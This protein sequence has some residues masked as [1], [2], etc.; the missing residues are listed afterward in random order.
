MISARAEAKR[1]FSG[2]KPILDKV[3]KA[4]DKREV[5]DILKMYDD[6]ISELEDPDA[7]KRSVHEYK[8]AYDRWLESAGFDTPETRNRE[9]IELL[10]ELNSLK[11]QIKKRLES[12]EKNERVRVEKEIAGLL[13]GFPEIAS[14][15]AQNLQET[16]MGRVV[17]LVDGYK[18]ILKSIT[19]SNQDKEPDPEK[20]EPVESQNKTGEG[21]QDSHE[22]PTQENPTHEQPRKTEER[23]TEYREGL[24]LVELDREALEKLFKE[25]ETI[26]KSLRE[27]LSGEENV[28]LSSFR[29]ALKKTLFNYC[30]NVLKMDKKEISAMHSAINELVDTVVED[31]GSILD[32]SL[33]LEAKKQTGFFKRKLAGI[34]GRAKLSW[35]V[36]ILT[37]LG[38][39]LL[40]RFFLPIGNRWA[41][42]GITGL[43][44]GMT[45]TVGQYASNLFSRWRRKRKGEVQSD[46]EEIQQKEQKMIDDKKKKLL[47]SEDFSLLNSDRLANIVAT[48]TYAETS[49]GVVD[50]DEKLDFSKMEQDESGKYSESEESKRGR[51]ELR[52]S[53]KSIYKNIETHVNHDPEY[54]DLVPR[55]KKLEIKRLFS[56]VVREQMNQEQ[57]M[58]IMRN[59]GK[60]N[61]E[62]AQSLAKFQ[63][64]VTGRKLA[65]NLDYEA[66]VNDMA[67]HSIVAGLVSGAT[68]IAM[69]AGGDYARAGL[70]ALGGATMGAMMFDVKKDKIFEE[71]VKSLD[72]IVSSSEGKIKDIIRS[73]D[74][75]A[76]DVHQ[77]LEQNIAYVRTVLSLKRDKDTPLIDDPALRTRAEGMIHQFNMIKARHGVSDIA[78]H[79]ERGEVYNI[80]NENRFY[81]VLGK[82]ER[83]LA[84][85]R[86]EMIAGVAEKVE[87]AEKRSKWKKK[88][89]MIVGGIAGGVLGYF[90]EDISGKVGGKIRDWL[91]LEQ[92][93]SQQ[94]APNQEPELEN[95]KN[96]PIE[97][98]GGSGG[99]SDSSPDSSRDSGEQFQESPESRQSESA[100]GDSS[101]TTGSSLPEVP[102]PESDLDFPEDAKLFEGSIDSKN[103]SIWKATK[104][105][106]LSHSEEF[107][108]DPKKH[109]D[110]KAWAERSTANAI[111]ELNELE[112]GNIKD[113]V[114]K[115]DRVYIGKGPDGKYHLSVED[116]PDD[117]FE[118]GHLS[119]SNV[120][121]IV[122]DE[123]VA[124]GVEVDNTGRSSLAGDQYVEYTK[125]GE[126]YRVYDWNRDGN[127]NVI[128]PDGT[129]VEMTPE[130]L[131]TYLRAEGIYESEITEA[132]DVEHGLENEVPDSVAQDIELAKETGSVAEETQGRLYDEEVK[133][134]KY[135]Q[136]SEF[137]DTVQG[138]LERGIIDDIKTGGPR[139]DGAVRNLS[140]LAGLSFKNGESMAFMEY[141]K[142]SHEGGATEAMSE[143]ISTDGHG[144][145]AFDNEAFEER[146]HEFDK[147][148]H[149]TD[150]P[151][152]KAGAEW[153][154]R[155]V[156]GGMLDGPRGSAEFKPGDF[157]QTALV[158]W[159]GTETRGHYEVLIPPNGETHTVTEAELKQLMSGKFDESAIGAWR[160]SIGAKSPDSSEIPSQPE[161]EASENNHDKV[162]DPRETTNQ[163]EEHESGYGHER[164]YYDKNA[165]ET[166]PD[167]M[168]E[169]KA[170]AIHKMKTA[171]VGLSDDD[172]DKAFSKFSSRT[173]SIA[174]GAF[175]IEGTGNAWSEA[176]QTKFVNQFN[177]FLAEERGSGLT[178]GEK[179]RL[180]NL[181]KQ[182]SGTRIQGN[183]RNLVEAE[184]ARLL[185][186][187]SESAVPV[188]SDA[189]HSHH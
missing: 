103:N 15:P 167:D 166:L 154:P 95:P 179:S 90:M 78:R 99:E 10:N 24:R 80:E 97:D 134:P 23:E 158:R 119:D 8:K 131:R 55:E 175:D 60:I 73:G 184:M 123:K 64:V 28:D 70:F 130:E 62:L 128:K 56:V 107:G 72:D 138:S 26:I 143:F 113:L 87:D 112:G 188:D 14:G 44:G 139:F 185:H 159:V 21:R 74:V 68:R 19:E 61:D 63:G 163:D 65:G 127:P 77:D 102:L 3:K 1:I 111:H 153:E 59:G 27:L 45:R 4:G 57:I 94:E 71:Y 38:V 151:P 69:G 89:A 136:N 171:V 181:Y 40:S 125:D 29:E 30:K 108:Y 183:A 122:K 92:K 96:L 85:D 100:E 157:Q 116:N 84:Q 162:T 147:I 36:T 7:F 126:T 25:D 52:K 104:N 178:D 165:Q 81:S 180:E 46:E 18:K 137:R 187:G 41:M 98:D 115:G 88:A 101:G 177:K 17:K 12:V 152:Q 109:G 6:K 67:K 20:A 144:N 58:D 83:N 35:S 135:L 141:L 172:Y 42:A 37:G 76:S 34:T 145:E 13:K 47:D 160:E 182:V 186:E 118:R 164:E 124:P 49:K 9:K 91:G 93:P 54:H 39:G 51:E 174:N 148:A 150:L 66:G 189:E 121:E 114:H 2:Y 32:E 133:N 106:F 50:L 155:M 82:M 5:E 129:S 176:G 33:E 16:H 170:Q 79:R 146:V 168:Q 48:R 132:G 31:V 149:S 86:D 105:L 161:S 169:Y 75:Y 120:S 43:V 140:E 110:L 173:Q 142:L 11:K 53:L 156:K 117:G 22:Q